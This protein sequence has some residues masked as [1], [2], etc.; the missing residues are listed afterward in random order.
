MGKAEM[1]ITFEHTMEGEPSVNVTSSVNEQENARLLAAA[2]CEQSE[3]DGTNAFDVLK[4]TIQQMQEEK[5]LRRGILFVDGNHSGVLEQSA[6]QY[7]GRNPR[8]VNLTVYPEGRDRYGI[9]R[10]PTLVY[11]DRRFVGSGAI[12]ESLKQA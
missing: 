11:Q 2:L 1:R 10:C 8:V 9:T 7:N 6:L 5:E 3:K 12:F 4:E